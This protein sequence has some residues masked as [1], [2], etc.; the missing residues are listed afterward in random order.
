MAEVL[1]DAPVSTPGVDPAAP[2]SGEPAGGKGK[3]ELA[4]ARERI[5]Q[6]ERSNTELSQ[7]ER[8]WADRFAEATRG[9]GGEPEG[10]EPEPKTPAAAKEEDDF[11][12]PAKF[13]DALST[14]GPKTIAAY[15]KKE[16]YI[17]AAEAEKLSE[18]T[19]KQAVAVARRSME[20]NAEL[21]GKH[22]ELNDESSPLFKETQKIYGEM[23]KRDP[24]LKKSNAALIT[25]ADLAAALIKLRDGAGRRKPGADDEDDTESERTRRIRQQSGDRSRRS[26]AAFDDTDDDSMTESQRT[27]AERLGLSADAYKDERKK[28]RAR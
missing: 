26:A 7:S 8:H 5:A 11:S 2:K 24:E 28:L 16:G 25:A 3:D 10:D 18:K 19:A 14:K 1:E 12:D 27:I 6:L 23:V 9:K 21:V 20:Q 4:Q 17:T 22:P 15:L 13:V